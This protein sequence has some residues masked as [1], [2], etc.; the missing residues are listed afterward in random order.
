MATTEARPSLFSVVFN[1]LG[2]LLQLTSVSTKVVATTLRI[3]DEAIEVKK[4]LSERKWGRMGATAVII[5]ADATSLALDCEQLKECWSGKKEDGS[6]PFYKQFQVGKTS[7]WEARRIAWKKNKP[8]LE[9]WLPSP[10]LQLRLASN[11]AHGYRIAIADREEP[12]LYLRAAS[13]LLET[14]RLYG[15]RYGEFSENLHTRLDWGE[16]FRWF[17]DNGLV[18]VCN[19]VGM[20]LDAIQISVWIPFEITI[21]RRDGDA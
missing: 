18:Q 6:T 10:V 11:L 20:P 1:G 13:G 17:S 12:H 8:H 4:D 16:D 7:D 19:A 9:R 3:C 21:R 5:A 15:V 2:T 14:V